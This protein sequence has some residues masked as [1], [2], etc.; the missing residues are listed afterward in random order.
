ME[1]ERRVALPWCYTCNMKGRRHS[2]SSV[3]MGTFAERQAY[4]MHAYLHEREICAT[5]QHRIFVKQ[6]DSTMCGIC[7]HA[8]YA[9]IRWTVHRHPTSG[10]S[11]MQLSIPELRF[12]SLQGKDRGHESS[13]N[14]DFAFMNMKCMRCMP[15]MHGTRTFY[16]I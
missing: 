4:R 2:F 14:L 1:P 3:C 13:A 10:T 16:K 8:S 15:Y 12:H 7:K 9:Q 11:A 6:R 5:T